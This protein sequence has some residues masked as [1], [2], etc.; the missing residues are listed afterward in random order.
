VPSTG[1]PKVPSTH[2]NWLF[3]SSG[4]IVCTGIGKAGF[5]AQKFAAVLCSTGTPAVFIHPAEAAHGDL[6]DR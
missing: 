4:K 6:A 2:L 5:V 3:Q 1:T